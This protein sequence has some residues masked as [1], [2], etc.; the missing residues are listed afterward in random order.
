MVARV[1]GT[2]SLGTDGKIQPVG[3]REYLR[4]YT[5]PVVVEIFATSFLSDII[6][7]GHLCF[8]NTW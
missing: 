6:S 5:V 7:H 3:G 2:L 4:D 8:F 1:R